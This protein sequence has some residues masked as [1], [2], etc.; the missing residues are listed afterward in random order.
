M[1]AKSQSYFNRLHEMYSSYDDNDSLMALAE[2][3]EQADRARVLAIYREQPKTMEIINSALTRYK[4]C[5]EKLTNSETAP[6]MTDMERAYCFAALDWCRY[7]L[8]IVGESPEHAN[9]Q[10]D[11]I[12]EEYARKAGLIPNR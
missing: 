9:A 5:I 11:L 3:S 8:D 1:N 7:T 6:K 10:V 2:V 4:N 12:L